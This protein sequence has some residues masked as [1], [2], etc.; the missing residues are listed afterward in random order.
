MLYKILKSSDE[1][2]HLLK[3]CLLKKL[4]EVLRIHILHL[5]D[6]AIGILLR[7]KNLRHPDVLIVILGRPKLFFCLQRKSLEILRVSCRFIHI[8]AISLVDHIYPASRMS[9][10]FYFHRYGNITFFYLWHGTSSW[11]PHS[12]TLASFIAQTIQS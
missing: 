5:D 12:H 11:L 8:D 4:N 10:Y 2:I 6:G 7:I 1:I 3:T 9:L